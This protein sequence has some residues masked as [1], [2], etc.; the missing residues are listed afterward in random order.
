MAEWKCVTARSLEQT[1]RDVMLVRA[2]LSV[3]LV[4][5]SKTFLNGGNI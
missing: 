1:P 5:G 2:G 4:P 3:R